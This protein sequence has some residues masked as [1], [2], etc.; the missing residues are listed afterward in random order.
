MS[1]PPDI[2][3][4]I[5]S[6][7]ITSAR[8]PRGGAGT[9]CAGFDDPPA[10]I[11]SPAHLVQYTLSS[12][13]GAVRG[14]PLLRVFPSPCTASDRGRVSRYDVSA[15]ARTSRRNLSISM[16][17]STPFR[18]LPRSRAPSSSRV[19]AS[20]TRARPSKTRSPPA[21]RRRRALDAAAGGDRRGR[22][23]RRRSTGAASSRC[24]SGSSGCCPR[25]SRTSPTARSCRPTRSTRC[26]GTLTALLA[27]A[28]RNGNGNGTA[29]AAGPAAD[30]RR[31]IPRTTMP[32][33]PVT[34][35][36]TRTSDDD[37]LDDE[38]EDDEDDDELE[39]VDEDSRTRTTRRR[40]SSTTARRRR[41]AGTG[42]TS[43]E[44]DEDVQLEEQPEDPNADRRFWF[45]HATGAG[46]TVAAL[47][48]V[49]ALA[50]RRRPDPH[51]PPQPRR[52]VQ[53]RAA[54]PRLPRPHPRAAAQRPRRRQRPGHGRDLPVVRAQRRPD[55]RRVHDRDLRRGAHRAG[56]EDL[57]VDPR[58]G[59]ARSSSA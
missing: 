49:E 3:G 41:G 28:Q 17:A 45:E 5:R 56:R 40:S 43:H 22:R 19:S 11:G 8:D 23:S 24:C 7:R 38:A 33:R 34:D 21:P 44:L 59:P 48:F 29:A 14:F 36:T 51:P 2:R 58:A 1:M 25:R 27:E 35:S 57:R 53:R 55:L 4:N 42:R 13:P 26:P 37:D 39:D 16:G 15:A 31:P 30:C 18:L 50:H 6:A 12:E 52:P 47:G 10:R 20:C 9:N 54:R 32:T 46:K